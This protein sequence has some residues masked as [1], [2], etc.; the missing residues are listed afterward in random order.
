MVQGTCARRTAR[1]KRKMSS[2]E[3]STIRTR[4]RAVERSEFM[5]SVT[6]C[7]AVDRECKRCQPGGQVVE[8]TDSPIAY[9]PWGLRIGKN[10]AATLAAASIGFAKHLEDAPAQNGEG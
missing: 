5:A 9:L 4:R 7:N 8:S 1:Q 10:L 2:S 6:Q 3:S